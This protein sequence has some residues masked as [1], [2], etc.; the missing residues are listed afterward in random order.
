MSDLLQAAS[1]ALDTPTDLVQRSAAARAAANGTTVD[2]VLSAWSGGAPVTSAPVAEATPAVETTTEVEPAPQPE[3]ATPVMVIEE[4]QPQPE[5]EPEPEE[6][7]EPVALGQRLKTAVRIGAWTGAALGVVG[8]L[9]ATAFWAPNALV[10][11]ESGPVVEVRPTSVMLGVALVSVVFGAVVA[12]MSRSATAWTNPAME[13]SG[14]KAGTAWLGGLLG[15]VLG[16]VAGA[17][18]SSFGTVVEGSDPEVTQLPVLATL[19]VMAIGGA[20]LGAATAAVPQLLGVPVAV[21]EADAEEVDVVKGRLSN[22]FGIPMVGLLLLLLLVLPFAWTLIESN[23][24]LPGAGGAVVA[25][26]AAGGILGFASLS[27][28]KTRDAD[29]IWRC[30]GCDCGNRHGPHHHHGRAVCKQR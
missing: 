6:P 25:I 19:A 22:A 5:Y 17:V 24:L 7:L 13:L 2:E 8:F 30:D 4:P 21:D 29:L 16:V 23:H 26:I 14:S 27:G 3:P 10:L 15:L 1:A 20:I 12:G 11:A 9:A 28:T 18:L